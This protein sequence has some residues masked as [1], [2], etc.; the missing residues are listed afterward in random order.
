MIKSAETD[1]E[2]SHMVELA[3]RGE[4]RNSDGGKAEKGV[5]DGQWLESGITSRETSDLR[6]GIKQTFENSM[7][8]T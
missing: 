4:R 7:R 3:E 2:T 6:K 1:P 5:Q 8:S